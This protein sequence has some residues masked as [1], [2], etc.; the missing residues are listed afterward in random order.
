MISVDSWSQQ[1]RDVIVSYGLAP[2]NKMIPNFIWT[3][4][5]EAEWQLGKERGR[6][7]NATRNPFYT[8]VITYCIL[9]A[10]IS[11]I[12]YLCQLVLCP[13]VIHYRRRVSDIIHFLS[14]CRTNKPL[15]LICQRR[16]NVPPTLQLL[17]D[18]YLFLF[19]FHLHTYTEIAY[20][21]T[22]EY[23]EV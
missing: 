19:R 20:S 17:S 23:R 16:G 10:D 13:W 5:P 6:R 2:E 18:H 8:Y 12:I 7:G 21:A 14:F 11:R 22:R 1:T 9:M 15:N 3:L 4:M